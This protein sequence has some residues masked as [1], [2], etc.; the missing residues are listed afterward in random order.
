MRDKV[1]CAEVETLRARP[2]GAHITRAAL[3]LHVLAVA[4]SVHTRHPEFIA[5][6]ALERIVPDATEAAIELWLA[7]LWERIDGGYALLDSEF[8]HHMGDQAAGHHIK[9][10]QWRLR[11]RAIGMCRRSWRALNSESVI[12]L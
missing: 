8:I 9:S 6:I 2:D 4:H 11:T 5:D 12:P 7:G 10:A 1:V 3:R